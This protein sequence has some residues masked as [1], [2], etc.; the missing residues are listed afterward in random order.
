MSIQHPMIGDLS[1]KTMQELEE[2]IAGLNKKMSFVSRS[3]NFG[4]IN[5]LMMALNSYRT[6]YAKR[7]DELYNKKSDKLVG[8][9][10]IQNTSK[11]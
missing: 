1:G 4:M 10:D 2:A 6:E 11:Y 9:I 3:N 8:K 5:Q 7:Q